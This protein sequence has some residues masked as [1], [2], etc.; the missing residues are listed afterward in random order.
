MKE[1]SS[2][3]TFLRQIIRKIRIFF[4]SSLSK[5]VLIF[6]IF[7]LISCFFWVLQ[8]LQEISEIDMDIPVSYSDVPA[9]ISITNKLPKT[10][11]VTLRDKG[12]NLYYYYRHRREL[13][14]NIDLMK[15][16]R[17][18]GIA[19]ISMSSFDSYFRNRL[20]STTQLLRFK[21]DTISVY[22]VEKASK[23]LPVHLNT[24][25]S[26]SA[27]HVLS[28]TPVVTPSGIEVYAP[29]VVLRK[30]N[31]IET[32]WLELD[33]LSDST[34]VTLKLVPVEGVHF[35]V[36]TVQVRLNVEEFTEQSLMIPVTGL[37]FPAGEELLSFP[38]SVK[39]TFFVGLSAYSR[40]SS[41]DFVISVDHASLIRSDKKSQKIVLIK[42]PVNIRNL[43]V[44]PETVDC[45]IEKR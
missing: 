22:F 31:R 9:R 40:I 4:K 39:V 43:R 1:S 14:I 27:Q 33:N 35:S 44:Q 30:L 29:A 36:K 32:E 2:I 5:E 28:D 7:L 19:R 20:M 24:R 26:L 12:T 13:T 17:R 42:T 6:L 34:V 45:L 41:G 37:N 21:L 15:W 38:P 16:Y 10:V 23:M 18:E 11:Q 3:L 8:S 25:L